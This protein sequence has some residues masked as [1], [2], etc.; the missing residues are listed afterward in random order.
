MSGQSSK[1]KGGCIVTPAPW[2]AAIAVALMPQSL[3]G[4]STTPL[5]FTGLQT[6]SRPVRLVAP[7]GVATSAGNL[8]VLDFQANQVIGAGRPQKTVA[9]GFTASTTKAADT[10][11]SA[12]KSTKEKNNGE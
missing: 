10:P 7:V 11:G 1:R 9:K 8:L 6:D 4:Q 5:V 12:S 2:M 3:S